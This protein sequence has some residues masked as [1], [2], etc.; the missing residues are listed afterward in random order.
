MAVLRPE[1]KG[2]EQITDVSTAVGLTVPS[3]ADRALVQAYTQAVRW[4][5]DGTDPTGS[6]GMVLAAGATL[7]YDGDLAAFRAIESASSAELNVTYYQ[8]G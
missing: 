5:D 1:P 3:G 7:A 4:R 8:G 6:V 2:Y